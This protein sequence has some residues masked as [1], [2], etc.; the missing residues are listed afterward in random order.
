MTDE[1]TQEAFRAMHQYLAEH[2]DERRES[3]RHWERAM[4]FLSSNDDEW[5][6]LYPN[7]WIAIRDEC[8]LLIEPDHEIFMQ[9]VRCLDV[10]RSE[11][12]T[13]FLAPLNTSLIPT[14][15]SE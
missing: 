6:A 5:R 8:L 3:K 2:A 9:K 11:I 7:S 13:W 4:A 15:Y 1:Q 12:H 14:L 10:P